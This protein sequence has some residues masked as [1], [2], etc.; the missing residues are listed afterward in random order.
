VLIITVAYNIYRIAAG[1]QTAP[2]TSTDIDAAN[3]ASAAAEAGPKPKSDLMAGAAELTGEPNPK[4][5][6]L[7]NEAV[8]LINAKP[9]R[10]IEARD[11]LNELLPIPQS[12]RQRAF[13]KE[14]L[15]ELSNKW[16]FSRTI[17]P[18]DGLCE[19]L[20]VAPGNMLSTIGKRHKVPHEILMNI[21]GI[22]NPQGLR[23]G[24]VIKVVNGPFHTRICRSTF[25]MD[26]YL[27][28]TFVRS[29]PVGLGRPGRETPT[30]LWHV[31]PNGKLISP[32]WRDPDTGKTYQ[33][34]DPDYPLGSRWIAIEGI[35]GQAVGRTGIAIHG[36]K[37]P[38]EIGT[39]G[40]RGCIRLHNGDAI[41]IYN[42]LVPQFSKVE[43]VQ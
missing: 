20:Q 35:K 23:A 29:F 7:I 37:D 2:Q 4:V 15:S 39:A 10:I 11:R 21:N 34:S 18:Q 9:S 14:R 19:T 22:R 27:Q 16:L 25:T 41:L 26:L 5:T 24:D 6:E 28:N 3:E 8:A 31:K 1:R 42:L 40:S 17:F 13:V 36:T 30:G 32:T 38:E 43:I 12:R 33:A